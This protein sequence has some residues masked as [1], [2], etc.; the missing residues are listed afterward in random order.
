MN[1]NKTNLI[2]FKI[3]IHAM[4]YLIS[5]PHSPRGKKCEVLLVVRGTLRGIVASQDSK[6]Q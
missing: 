1:N 2:V 4:T 6:K 5:A 3:F